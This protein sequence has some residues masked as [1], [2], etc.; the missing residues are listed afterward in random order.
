MLALC[1][2]LAGC[3]A[4]DSLATVW[5]SELTVQHQIIDKLMSYA[6]SLLDSG[7]FYGGRFACYYSMRCYSMRF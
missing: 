3:T 7:Q 5:D 2:I 4:N 6:G 1:S